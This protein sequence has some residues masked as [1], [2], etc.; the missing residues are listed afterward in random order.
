MLSTLN[1]LQTTNI[2]V[3]FLLDSKCGHHLNLLVKGLSESAR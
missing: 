2:T 1:E 3:D